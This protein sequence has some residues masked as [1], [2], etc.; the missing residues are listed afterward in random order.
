M[1]AQRQRSSGHAFLGSVSSILWF[2]VVDASGSWG[3][4]ILTDLPPE[5]S[6]YAP[7]FSR[8]TGSRVHLLPSAL[9][10]GKSCATYLERSCMV[11]ISPTILTVE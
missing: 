1:L 8:A 10:R 3:G 5:T 2:W 11:A 7:T 4:L 6:V 9:H